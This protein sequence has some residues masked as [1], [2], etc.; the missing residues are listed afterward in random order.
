M[1]ISV[2][3]WVKWVN[4]SEFL[5]NFEFLQLCSFRYTANTRSRR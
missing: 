4:I 1:P 2:R 3:F 5:T